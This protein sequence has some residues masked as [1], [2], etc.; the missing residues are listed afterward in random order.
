[1]HPGPTPHTHKQRGRNTA[2]PQNQSMRGKAAIRACHTRPHAALD[3]NIQRTSK[4][5]RNVL[6]E[7]KYEQQGEE[8]QRAHTHHPMRPKQRT[9]SPP[10]P[11]P[12]WTVSV[13][14][15]PQT[16]DGSPRSADRAPDRGRGQ[17]GG[18]AHSLHTP[19]QRGEEQQRR[20]ARE[21]T[22]PSSS[23]R[24]ERQHAA[25]SKCLASL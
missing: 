2:A 14:A 11:A 23:V 7:R 22:R 25:T 17:E 12:H 21:R 6:A 9:L 8:E 4:L 3:P 10:P 19:P 13:R 15:T 16:C 1:M 24:S 20:G 5:N 18:G